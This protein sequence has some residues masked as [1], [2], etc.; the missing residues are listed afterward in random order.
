MTSYPLH[1]TD[2]S[3]LTH[4]AENDM[5][6]HYLDKP[7]PEPRALVYEYVLSF[8]ISLK[9]ATKMQP[10]IKKLTGIETATEYHK[11]D[12]LRPVNTSILRV[13]MLIY[14]EAVPVSYKN[15][16]FLT[17]FISKV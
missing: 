3:S 4:T 6:C 15:N 14:L 13:S 12:S 11:K 10:F 7:A 16:T 9:H 17:R 8:G 2:T 1:S 5:S